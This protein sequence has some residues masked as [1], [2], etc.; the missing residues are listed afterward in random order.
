M[1]RKAYGY[2]GFGDIFVFLF[3]G[4]LGVVGTYFL[5]VKQIDLLIFLPATSIGLLSVGVLNL[6]NMRDRDS[7]LKAN[8]KTIVVK[9]GEE[10]AKYYHYYLLGSAFLLTLLYVILDYR[11]PQQLLFCIAFIPI[12]RHLI[13]VY[14]NTKAKDLDSELKKL[15]LSTFLFALLFALGQIL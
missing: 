8:K 6:N 5:F 3:F 11:S 9:I 1:G 2:Y 14:N 13:V 10:F 15:A 4:W 7:D 12:I